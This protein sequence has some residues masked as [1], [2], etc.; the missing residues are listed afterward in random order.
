MW[1]TEQV[2]GERTWSERMFIGGKW[3]KMKAINMR[4]LCV[5]WGQWARR[6]D[7]DDAC[8]VWEGELP[9]SL[10]EPCEG[11]SRARREVCFRGLVHYHHGRKHGSVQ[12]D[13]VLE[14]ELRVL[15]LKAF[16]MSVFHRGN[17]LSTRSPQ[18]PP[19]LWCTSSIPTRPHLLI[20]ALPMGQA[21]SNHHSC[22]SPYMLPSHTLSCFSRLRNLHDFFPAVHSI[23]SPFL[24]GFDS[25]PLIT[26][27]TLIP[28]THLLPCNYGSLGTWPSW[29][30]TASW[31]WC[32]ARLHLRALAYLP[33]HQVM[34]WNSAFPML[35]DGEAG[36]PHR[37]A[38][39]QLTTTW[40]EVC[41]CPKPLLFL[42]CHIYLF[43]K[44]LAGDWRDG[45]M[46]KSTD[47]SSKG[48]ELKSQQP[49]G[50]SQPSVMRSD[51][52]FWCV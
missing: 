5:A 42:I 17:S 13:M 44:K 23:F 22:L 7:P 50:G 51:A 28:H 3:R 18:C 40:G 35:I 2:V 32:H 11:C 20:V 45:P 4:A 38:A 6:W 24:L 10:R 12:A 15:Y 1:G 48:P 41:P 14:K 27:L 19:P 30:P 52:L 9:T 16:R 36:S 39:G 34:C 25:H 43:I 37:R 29:W 49:H 21:Y 8:C 46:V 47:Y 31:V 33:K 26:Q